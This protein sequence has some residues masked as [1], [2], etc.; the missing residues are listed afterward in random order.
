MMRRTPIRRLLVRALLPGLLLAA[1]VYFTHHALYDAH[2][3]R[4]L[5]SLSD[6]VARREAELS[7]IRARREA[8]E[9]RVKALYNQSLDPDLLDERARTV[10]GLGRTDEIVIFR[11]PE[12]P[13]DG[14]PAP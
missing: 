11:G 10:L 12:N 13:V 3:L 1:A 4:R 7:E 9:S 14:A 8:L 5:M 2:G 6:E